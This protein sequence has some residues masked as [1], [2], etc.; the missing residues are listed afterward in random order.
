[1]RTETDKSGIKPLGDGYIIKQLDPLLFDRFN[2][3]IIQASVLRCAK[4]KELDYRDSDTQSKII[5]SLIERM[6]KH[7][8]SKE[9][10]GLSE[11]LLALCLKRL[12][13]KKNHLPDFKNHP[14]DQVRHPIAWILAEQLQ[15]PLAKDN[16]V[17]L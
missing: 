2:E 3:G 17:P 5:G 14:L 1:L 9:S 15:Q 12:Q 4:S 6:L 16:D 10:S 7:P 8:D 13:I 11:F